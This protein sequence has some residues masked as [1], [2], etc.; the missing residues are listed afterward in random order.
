[1][2]VLLLDDKQQI[3]TAGI[4]HEASYRQDELINFRII[5]DKASSLADH[6][7]PTR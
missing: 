7:E 4:N 5:L 3:Q 2:F 6:W 1:M